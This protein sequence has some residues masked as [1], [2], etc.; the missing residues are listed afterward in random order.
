MEE[1]IL[2]LIKSESTET[3]QVYKVIN[4]TSEVMENIKKFLFK[5]PSSAN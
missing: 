3:H 1:P 4:G 5:T 2:T